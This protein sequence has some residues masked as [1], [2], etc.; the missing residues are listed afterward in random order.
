[1]INK[2]WPSDKEIKVIQGRSKC[3]KFNREWSCFDLSDCKHNK[4]VVD[5]AGKWE[6]ALCS[7]CG[8]FIHKV[9]THEM[10]WNEDGTLL[11]CNIC[12]I[13]GT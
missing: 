10:I 5:Y 8:S 2:S 7:D 1:M 11:R 12:G 9:C 13:D 3:N 4:N 6:V